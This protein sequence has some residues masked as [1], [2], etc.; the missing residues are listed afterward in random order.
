MKYVKIALVTLLLCAL[1]PASPGKSID[2]SIYFTQNVRGELY[3]C[4]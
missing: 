2:L 4:G 3:P 1:Q